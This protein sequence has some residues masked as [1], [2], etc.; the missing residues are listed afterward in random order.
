M[1]TTLETLDRTERCDACGAQAYYW[2]YEVYGTTLKW[3]SHH[4]TKYETKMLALCSGYRD[5][6]YLLDPVP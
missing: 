1:S 5:L 4:G 2:F 6:R 3:C